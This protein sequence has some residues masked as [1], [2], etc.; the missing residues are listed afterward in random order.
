LRVEVD[1]AR[2]DGSVFF[3]LDDMMVVY[4][5]TFCVCV[6]R[7]NESLLSIDQRDHPTRHHPYHHR[8]YNFFALFVEG[9]NP[10]LPERLTPVEISNRHVIKSKVNAF[11]SI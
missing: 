10:N 8:L 9:E 2:E 1:F 7:E 5:S 11:T 6:C 3:V 4:E